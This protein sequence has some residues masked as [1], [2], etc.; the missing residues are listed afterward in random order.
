MDGWTSM[1]LSGLAW[2]TEWVWRSS[3]EIRWV[4]ISAFLA[5][6]MWSHIFLYSVRHSFCFCTVSSYTL[7]TSYDNWSF[8]PHAIYS[9]H[10]TLRFPRKKPNNN[11]ISAN[12]RKFVNQKGGI[13]LTVDFPRD[14]QVSWRMSMTPEWCDEESQPYGTGEICA[15][16]TDAE[17]SP[18]IERA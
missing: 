14:W 12:F 7:V 5:S 6:F 1:V 18:Q 3:E 16:P 8:G 17:P 2:E 9:F 10:S 15:S 4:G 11:G 13:G